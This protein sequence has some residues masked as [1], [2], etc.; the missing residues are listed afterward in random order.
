MF[1]LPHTTIIVIC[2]GCSGKPEGPL[3][4]SE[5]LERSCFGCSMKSSGKPSETSS[6]SLDCLYILSD[7]NLTNRS[8]LTGKIILESVIFIELFVLSITACTF[9]VARGGHD[10]SYLGPIL[11]AAMLVLIFY[12]LI[13]VC[14][15]ILYFLVQFGKF[16]LLSGTDLQMKWS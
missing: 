13:Q 6:E 4:K 5:E 8:A 15:S 16:C 9:R 3:E 14:L 7:V 11:F 1:L 12:G 2:C 10:F